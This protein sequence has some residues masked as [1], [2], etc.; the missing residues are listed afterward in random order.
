MLLDQ[1]SMSFKAVPV[2]LPTSDYLAP[3]T[4]VPVILLAIGSL[5]KFV[6]IPQSKPNQK[7]L[8][9]EEKNRSKNE[10]TMKNLSRIT[11]S[12]SIKNF[13]L[14]KISF[15]LYGWSK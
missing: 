15:L 13:L 14:V 3:P 2:I 1:K 6:R 9:L 11:K 8:L 5:A 4:S 7:Y 12:Y 10:K